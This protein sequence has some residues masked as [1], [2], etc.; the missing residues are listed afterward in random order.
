METKVYVDVLLV[1]NY[2]INTLLIL[3]TAKLTGRKPKRRRIVAAALFGSAS[4]L[5]IFLPFFGFAGGILTKL[6]LAA[7]IVRIAFPRAGWRSYAKELFAFFA[8]SFFFSGVMLAVWMTFSPDG[9]LYYNGVVYFDI[10]PF[11]LVVTTIAAYGALSLAN[12]FARGGRV[13]A[14][15]YRAE[16]AYRGKTAAVRGLVDTGNS[17]YEPFSDIPVMVCRVDDVGSL[18]PPGAADGIRRGEHLGPAFAE[19]GLP[20]RLI[21]Y[22][23]VGGGGMIPAFRPERVTL[24]GEGGTYQVENVYV[25]ITVEKVGG[26]GF[27][28]ILNPDLIGIRI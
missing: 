3:C 22:G 16:I 17:L 11:T 21:P 13:K 6:A 8:V 28:A 25:G 18:L 27:D 2:V 23:S 14:A 1:L 20:V 4:A 15:V 24:T 26:A 19:Y 10:S 12:R 5:T 7:A 9:M